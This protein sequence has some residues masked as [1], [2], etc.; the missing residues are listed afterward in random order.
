MEIRKYQ[1][2][3]C[4]EISQLFYNTVHSVNIKDYSQAQ[5][6]AWAT[7]TVNID[8]WNESFL[9]NY[10]IVA[11]ENGIIAGFGDIDHT[12]YLDHLFVHKDYQ[13]K[14]IATSICNAIE[15]HV[16]GNGIQIVYTHASIT[17]KPFFLKRGYKV[18]KEQQVERRGVKLT[19]FVMEKTS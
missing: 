1:P 16:T 10:S 17:A 19:N 8:K 4:E 18:K 15:D 2:A 12:G 14:G 6:D 13:S 7:G 11:V 9:K 5:V 3:D